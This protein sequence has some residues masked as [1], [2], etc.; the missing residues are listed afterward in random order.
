[1]NLFIIV[2]IWIRHMVVG[3][4]TSLC[5]SMGQRQNQN[6]VSAHG[7]GNRLRRIVGFA[8]SPSQS[9]SSTKSSH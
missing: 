5:C 1:M 3:C 8:P 6:Y 7:V 2:W 4:V 9:G